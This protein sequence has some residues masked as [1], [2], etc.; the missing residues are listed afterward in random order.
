MELLSSSGLLVR[1][2][3]DDK[4]AKDTKNKHLFLLFQ[5]QSVRAN[6]WKPAIH[7]RGNE[8]SFI[9]PD[10]ALAALVALQPARPPARPPVR[11]T[12]ACQAAPAFGRTDPMS[13]RPGPEVRQAKRRS[14]LASRFADWPLIKTLHS[15]EAPRAAA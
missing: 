2:L 7:W 12:C 10:L 11:P 8:S 15:I 5:V 13:L 6:Q 14:S 1:A 4:P 3:A 9:L